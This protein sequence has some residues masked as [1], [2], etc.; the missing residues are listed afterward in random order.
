MLGPKFKKLGLR[1]KDREIN[2][3]LKI[4]KNWGKQT[5]SK[6]VQEIKKK[7]SEGTLP[8]APEDLIDAI[9]RNNLGLS[10]SEVI[11]TE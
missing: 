9:V 4:L 6:R 10:Q 11:Y 7:A 5:I 2:E 1:R 8:E 3:K